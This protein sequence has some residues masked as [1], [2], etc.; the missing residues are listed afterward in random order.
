MS[1][2]AIRIQAE[3]CITATEIMERRQEARER[4]RNTAM[5]DMLDQLYQAHPSAL[6]TVRTQWDRY[7]VETS[8]SNQIVIS[9]NAAA[10][11]VE[12]TFGMTDILDHMGA[13]T[14]TQ[15]DEEECDTLPE[16][17][18]PQEGFTQDP[19]HATPLRP[20]GTEFD[21][22]GDE[23]DSDITMGEA[24][25]WFRDRSPEPECAPGCELHIQD[26]GCSLCRDNPCPHDTEAVAVNHECSPD[27]PECRVA[28]RAEAL[29]GAID[30]AIGC[31]S[32]EP[33][34]NACP[35]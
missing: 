17:I 11:T 15:P 14:P 9:N 22:M 24:E 20:E 3:R 2:E 8:S 28:D 35:S 16:T 25:K 6:G 27:C 26:D 7:S 1:L 21:T 32:C 5:T 12:F 18:D 30:A 23:H 13:D 31:P 10:N 4:Q 33:E 34:D 29:V 19:V